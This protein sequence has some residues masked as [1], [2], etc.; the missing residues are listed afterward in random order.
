MNQPVNN[1]HRYEL[2]NAV[3]IVWPSLIILHPLRTL[4]NT[5]TMTLPP[6]IYRITQWGT[7]GQ[8]QVL[9]VDSD[10]NVTV[11]SPSEAPDKAQEVTL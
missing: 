5:N 10:E 11:A 3:Y 1:K 6:G 9:T 4:P 2:W 7:H 8:P